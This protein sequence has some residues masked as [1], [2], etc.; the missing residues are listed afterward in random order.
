MPSV[1]AQPGHFYAIGIGPGA[2]DLLT[3]RAVNLIESSDII[4]SPQAEGT[5]RSLALAAI[6]PYLK[7]QQI[8]TINYQMKRD[9]QS[10][11]DRWDAVAQEVL[12]D[13]GAGKSVTM[14][15]IG[16]P[17]IFAT[18]SYLLQG[19]EAGMDK[20]KIQVVPGISAFQIAASRF[21]D[22]LTLQEDRLM[23][24]SATDLAAVEAALIHC[25]TLILYKA[26]GVINELLA[27]L[28]KHDLLAAA[29]LVSCAEQGA[30]ELVV[31]DLSRFSPES[32][33]YMTTMIIHCGRRNWH[34]H[35]LA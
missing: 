10:T 32:L 35:V 16:D 5:N 18:T 7:N 3:V 24:M 6:G 23:L 4:L 12:S 30:G 28:S 14:I 15:T 33:S 13:C 25:E 8:K 19:L 31:E 34:D 17:L 20:C 1:Q 2:S 9:G 26:G 21:H 11:Q 22:A 29:R 27:L